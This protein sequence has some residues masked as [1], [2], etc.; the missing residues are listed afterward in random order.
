MAKRTTTYLID[1]LDG[2]LVDEEGRTVP[3]MLAGTDYEIDLSSEHIE[4]LRAAF[5]P[6]IAAGRKM[7]NGRG[8]APQPLS[9]AAKSGD[10]AERS[11][12]RAWLRENG[13]KVGVRGRISGELLALFHD[14]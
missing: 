1:D 7:P 12:A 11:E 2:T 13:H 8:A 14:R 3:F 5:A 10:A 4:E 9:R 6:Y